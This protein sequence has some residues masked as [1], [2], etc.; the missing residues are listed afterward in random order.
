[1]TYNKEINEVLYIIY[2]ENQ[3]NKEF[4]ENLENLHITNNKLFQN[5]VIIM[6]NYSQIIFTT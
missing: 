6:S 1:M 3:E 5:Q 4:S 2:A